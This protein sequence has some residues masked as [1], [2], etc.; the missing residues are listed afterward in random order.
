M[1][2]V[3][4]CDE[5]QALCPGASNSAHFNLVLACDGQTADN[6]SH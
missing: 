2:V 1:H 6:F 3:A 4:A 5:A